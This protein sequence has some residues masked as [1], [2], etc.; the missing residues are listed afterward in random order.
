MDTNSSFQKAFSS[1][2]I[3][4]AIILGLGIAAW[5]MYR[6]LEQK[7]FIPT[8]TQRGNYRWIDANKNGL[9]D[10][11]NPQEFVQGK[12]G[13]YRLQVIGDVLQ[14]INWSWKSFLWLGLALI[15]MVGRDFAYMLRIKILTQQRLNWK[16]SF[17]VIM[18]W[19]FASALSP[20]VLG[21]TTVAMFILNREKI[22]L[23]RSTAI[24]VITAMLDNLFYV[25]LVP[26]V[27]IFI[28]KTALFPSATTAEQSVEIAFWIGYG[29]FTTICVLLLISIFKYPQ[30]M[31]RLLQFIF[32]LPFLKKGRAKAIQ[33][34]KEIITTSKELQQESWTFWL[35]SF[36][37]TVLSWSSRYLVI[38][39]ILAAFLPITVGNH[40]FIFGKQLILWL[41]MRVSP[42]PGG[43]GVAEYAF[44]E[45]MSDFSQSALLLAALALIWRLISYFPYLFIGA[46]LLPRWIKNTAN[47]SERA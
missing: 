29:L 13:N 38:N 12:H 31:S 35:K 36:G 3:A 46:F 37:A 16:A 7:Q 2:K 24:V 30:L 26:L 15:C 40:F 47:T 18:L 43:S 22:E 34:G 19:E 17:N 21:G 1:W 44:G 5:M 32:R 42:T 28:S 9:V 41:L 8:E 23:G 11:H 20:G 14:A 25:L 10:V 27:F 45:L 39:C 6:S 4:L 33:T